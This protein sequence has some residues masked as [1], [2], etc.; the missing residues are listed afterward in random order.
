LANVPAM[1]PSALSAQGDV[2]F[3]ARLFSLV[4]FDAAFAAR[5]IVYFEPGDA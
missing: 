5:A 3:L 4:L 1:M 2:G